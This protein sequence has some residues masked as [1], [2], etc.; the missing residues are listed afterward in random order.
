MQYF[1]MFLPVIVILALFIWSVVKHKF[2]I[3][4]FSGCIIFTVLLNAG[5]LTG[6]DL[7]AGIARLLAAAVVQAMLLYVIAE[8]AFRL[9]KRKRELRDLKD[10]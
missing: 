5:Q 10:K 8:M 2:H 1:V 6:T 9:S 4:I 7:P 3:K